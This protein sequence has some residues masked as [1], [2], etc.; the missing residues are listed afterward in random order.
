MGVQDGPLNFAVAAQVIPDSTVLG[1]AHYTL[2]DVPPSCSPDWP[3]KD[4]EP[5]AV[6]YFETGNGFLEFMHLIAQRRPF[7]CS[8][9]VENLDPMFVMEHGL[10]MGDIHLEGPLCATPQSC[11]Q[12]ITAPPVSRCAGNFWAAVQ[13][14]PFVQAE[15]PGLARSAIKGSAMSATLWQGSYEMYLTKPN[16]PPAPPTSP[17]YTVLPQQPPAT[18]SHWIQD[19]LSLRLDGPDPAHPGILQIV[20]V[21]ADGIGGP[22]AFQ[23]NSSSTAWATSSGFDIQHG[24]TGPPLINH[25]DYCLSEITLYLVRRDASE[26]IRNPSV[27]CRGSY[28]LKTALGAVPKPDY[29]N[30]PAGYWDDATMYGTPLGPLYTATDAS[31]RLCLLQGDDY[32]I[33]PKVEFPNGTAQ[34]PGLSDLKVGC[35]VCYEIHISHD[36]VGPMFDVNSGCA[37]LASYTLQGI[38][39]ADVINGHLITEVSYSLNNIPIVP[40]LYMGSGVPSFDL[41]TSLMSLITLQP[42]V[43]TIEVSATDNFGISDKATFTITLDSTPPVL[44]G[45]TNIFTNSLAGTNGNFVSYPL[46]TALDNCDGPV[47]VNCALP[48][49]SF[50]PIGQTVVTCTAKDKCGNTSTCQFNV[51]VTNPCPELVINGSFETTSPVVVINSFNN[52]LNPVTGLPSWT[53]ASQFLEVWRDPFGDIPASE[54]THHLEINAQSDN[55]TV[56]QVLTGLRTNCPVTFCFDYTGR[57]DQVEGGYNNDFTVTLSG[58]ASLSVPLNPAIYSVGGWQTFCTNFVPA[59]STLTIAFHG[60]PHFTDGTAETQGGAHI[61]NVSLTQCCCPPNRT[62]RIV[63]SSG[64]IIISWSGANYRLQT[65]TSLTPIVVW[66][67]LPG[68]SP[69][70]IPVSETAR[71]FRLVCP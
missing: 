28:G 10:L 35:G 58:G 18:F 44:G 26:M 2:L 24:Q 5:G 53:T 15:G 17:C 7:K 47:P 69:I 13:F 25:H 62:L 30:S 36:G 43:N 22:G 55:E 12:L 9:P 31:I 67:D 3:Y 16:D 49:G 32:T 6:F 42:C 50:F 59:S 61:D 45:C 34:F 27:N 39:Q 19:L 23:V 38:V 54:G 68:T 37:S 57:F 65:T 66:T 52:T 33:T 14:A 11:L 63:Y 60:Q 4:Y 8:G 48:S 70:T 1:A 20:D 64:N 21:Y 71:F 46:P 41:S 51:T 40:P 56:S 29:K